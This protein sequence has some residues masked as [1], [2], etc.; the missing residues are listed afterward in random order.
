[1]S[2]RGGMKFIT[3]HLSCGI[4]IF[5][6]SQSEDELEVTDETPATRTG[7]AAATVPTPHLCLTSGEG[8]LGLEV[9]TCGGDLGG[10]EHTE[11]LPCLTSTAMGVFRVGMED[12]GLQLLRCKQEEESGKEEPSRLLQVLK[13]SSS[14]YLFFYQNGVS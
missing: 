7:T 8:G 14:L 1:M 10:E 4:T 5:S 11:F 2:E 6:C 9:R 3:K 12:S 13:W